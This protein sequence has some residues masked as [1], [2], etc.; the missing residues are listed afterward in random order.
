[1]LKHLKELFAV[2]ES[3]DPTEH[4]IHL[5][6]AAL[7]IEVARADHTQSDDE[8]QAMTTLLANS[9]G[10]PTQEVAELISR[11]NSAVDE[12]TSLFEFTRL[13]NE[14][15]GP[16]EK[17]HL[18]EAMWRVAYADEQLDKYEEHI[19]RRVAELIYVPHADF[20]QLKHAA[21]RGA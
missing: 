9:L 1:M 18:V 7:L 5:A 13:V 20:V 10:L 15:Y 16:A 17:R 6:A 21:K 2:P 8:Q 11:A 12:A 19:I 3:Q 14:V 4:D